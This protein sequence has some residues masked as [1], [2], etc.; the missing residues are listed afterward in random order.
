M[1]DA[2]FIA[3]LEGC[4]L[5]PAEFDHAAHVRAGYL[6]LREGT[7]GRSIDRMEAAIRRYAGVLGMSDRY[8]D[9]ITVAFLALIRRHLYER[10]DGDGWEGF[11]AENPELFDHELLL[12]FFPKAQLESPLARRVFVLPQL[13]R[14]P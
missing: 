9:T 11:A 10:G 6:Y 12:R 3:S 13:G 14:T 1:N 2:E 5:P 4:T 7:F 8:H